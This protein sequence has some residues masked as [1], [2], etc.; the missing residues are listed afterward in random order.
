MAMRMSGLMSGMDTESIV[1]ELVAV[2]KTK[3]DD[4]KK[5]QTK[6]EW[7]QD[8]WKELNN[9]VKKLAIESY[10][11]IEENKNRAYENGL[12]RVIKSMVTFVKDNES[13]TL[14][15]LENASKVFGIKKST[16]CTM[17]KRYGNKDI[18][19]PSG[20]M[21]GYKIITNMCKCK[22]QRLSE[23]SRA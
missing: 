4:M 16:L 10:K 17:I 7:K 19:I 13:F 22:V 15:G 18:K 21:K 3:V 6:L 20:S 14:L 5:E 9:K 23:R 2:R 1:Q 12:G 8:A 11:D